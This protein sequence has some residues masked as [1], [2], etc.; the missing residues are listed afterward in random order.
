MRITLRPDLPGLLRARIN[1][2]KDCN[3]V[4]GWWDR[5]KRI[6]GGTFEVETEHLFQDQFNCADP[7]GGMGFRVMNW[8]VA[9]IDDDARDGMMRC[10]WC[11]KT[12]PVSASCAGCGNDGVKPPLHDGTFG[13]VKYSVPV[14]NQVFVPVGEMRQLPYGSV[15]LHYWTAPA[16]AFR[17]LVE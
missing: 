17:G 11:G 1:L 14:R 13:G 10:G 8:M 6:S 16:A 7:E 9:A 3:P 15:P 5:L 4:Q 2:G 12:Q